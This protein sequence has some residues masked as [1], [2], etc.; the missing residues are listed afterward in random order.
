M[1]DFEFVAYEYGAMR[2][3]FCE[4]GHIR[5]G[6]S[7]LFLRASGNKDVISLNGGTR[8]PWSCGTWEDAYE[9]I[10]QASERGDVIILMRE[11]VNA[12]R[13]RR[14]I[15]RLEEEVAELTD[16]W[17]FRA[18]DGDAP[19]RVVNI[20]RLEAGVT[21][22]CYLGTCFRVVSGGFRGW[23]LSDGSR[24]SDTDML[25]VFRAAADCGSYAVVNDRG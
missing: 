9:A 13:L 5:Q 21:V 20:E 12:E 25:A 19:F 1:S 15:A 16:P 2:R 11:G 6:D 17:G 23:V 24:K 22:R 18:W 4:L 14:R 8:G 10:R 7:L 3:A